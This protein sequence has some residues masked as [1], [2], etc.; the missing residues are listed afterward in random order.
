MQLVLINIS[1]H[2]MRAKQLARDGA[3]PRVIGCLLGQHSG[4][5]VD[6]V[7]SFEMVERPR[8][9]GDAGYDAD[10]YAQ[11]LE[12]YQEVFKSVDVIGWYA[13]GAGLQASDL[14]VHRQLA[15]QC[16]APILL[17][18]NPAAATQVGAKELPLA[19]YESGVRCCGATS[20][21]CTSLNC[22]S[23]EAWAAR[24]LG[25]ACSG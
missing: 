15:E 13:T 2:A 23:C 19:L 1:D 4:R 7:N 10:T 20:A 24:S 17:S 6:V 8:S 14:S 3:F 25:C 12:Q 18:M 16:E 11:K 9:N 22:R 5:T 21:W